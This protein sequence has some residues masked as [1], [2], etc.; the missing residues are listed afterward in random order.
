MEKV[1]NDMLE[2]E[3]CPRCGLEQLSDERGGYFRHW[4][5]EAGDFG[6]CKECGWLPELAEKNKCT[7]EMRNLLTRAVGLS[8]VPYDEWSDWLKDST[9]YRHQDPPGP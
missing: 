4:I 1:M 8:G 2:L 9:P 6:Q 5:G 7:T 3:A